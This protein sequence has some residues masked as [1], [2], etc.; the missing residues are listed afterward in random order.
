MKLPEAIYQG[1]LRT[2]V[3]P[4]RRLFLY[5]TLVQAITTTTVNLFEVP[6]G[7]DFILQSLVI[8]AVG[9]GAQTVTRF[10]MTL[11]SMEDLGETFP[12]ETHHKIVSGLVE[13]VYEWQGELYVPSLTRV[14]TSVDFSAGAIANTNYT[15]ATGFLVPQLELMK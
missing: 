8:R 12:Y 15:Y 10:K 13:D 6:Q 3:V 4:P 14:K 11:T 5:K 2:P 9:G 1:Y 7:Y